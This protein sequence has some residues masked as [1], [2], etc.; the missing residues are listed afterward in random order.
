[1][2]IAELF[3]PLAAR[4]TVGLFVL[5][6]G[7]AVSAGLFAEG[8]MLAVVKEAVVWAL[9]LLVPTAMVAAGTGL[10]L[11]RARPGPITERKRRRLRLI[12][13]IGVVILL[14][15]ALV[16]DALAQ[17]ES[18]DVTLFAVVQGIELVAGFVTL[19]LLGLS[20]R[21]GLLAKREAAVAAARS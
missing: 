12:T 16:L 15:A 9:F 7:A 21:D 18:V 3:H 2:L 5:I 8:E 11:T 6:W 1:M 19:V 4:V 13:A 20:V 10:V 17:A 14:P